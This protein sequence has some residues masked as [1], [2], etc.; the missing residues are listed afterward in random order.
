MGSHY[1]ALISSNQ[2]PLA[3][4][5]RG[6]GA[7]GPWGPGDHLRRGGCRQGLEHEDLDAENSK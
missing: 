1:L 5:L 2:R 4:Q 6:P 7:L 3:L